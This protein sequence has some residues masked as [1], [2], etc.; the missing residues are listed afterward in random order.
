MGAGAHAGVHQDGAALGAD[1]VGGQV[2]PDLVPVHQVLAVAAPLVVGL[3]VG[4]EVAQVELK[5]PVGQGNNL[6]VPHRNP[7]TGHDAPPA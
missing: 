7:I 2:E 5:N 3:V 1:E 4:K 6:H